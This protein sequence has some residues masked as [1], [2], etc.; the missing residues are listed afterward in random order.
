M[1]I[2]PNGKGE[3]LLVLPDAVEIVIHLFLILID[4]IDVILGL[5][6]L[7]HIAVL[8]SLILIDLI[9]VPYLHRTK[10]PN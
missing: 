6:Q 2:A 8:C 4:L 9:D 1:R 5:L 7:L 3:V 10:W